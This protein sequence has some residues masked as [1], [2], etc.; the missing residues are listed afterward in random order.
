[1]CSVSRH[2]A[3]DSIGW[4]HFEFFSSSFESPQVLDVAI[5][6]VPDPAMFHY[7]FRCLS[8]EAACSCDQRVLVLLQFELSSLNERE[9]VYSSIGGI[10]TFVFDVLTNC[11]MLFCA[12]R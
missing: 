10:I 8:C 2:D 4:Q 5:L 12:L 11:G 6:Q 3:R 9:L 1:M 7:P